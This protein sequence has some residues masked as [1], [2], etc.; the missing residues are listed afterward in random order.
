MTQAGCPLKQED[1]A[2][3]R[4]VAISFAPCH[5]LQ[6]E[7]K[8]FLLN[9][10]ALSPDPI[11]N[12]SARLLVV[13]D[14]P[15]VLLALSEIMREAGFEVFA[16]RDGEEALVLARKHPPDLV[17]LDVVLPDISG[18]D[19][20]R[21]I[22]AD[23]D[24]K[25]LFVVLLS[26]SETSPDSQVSGLDAG[27]DGYIARPIE[28]RELV[29]RVQSLLRIQRAEMALRKAHDELEQRVQDRTEALAR[30]NAGLRKMS[31]RLLEVQETE[32][33][34]LARELHDE[35]GQ[36]LT[37]LKMVVDRS[38]SAASE[39]MTGLLNEAVDLI[40]MLT[41]RMRDLSVQLRPQVLDDLGL[42]V[43]LEWHFQR[44]FTQT[45][46]QVHFSHTPITKRLPVLLETALFR[47]TLEAL[48]NVARHAGVSEV[49]V[50]VWVDSERVGLQVEDKGAGFDVDRIA[51]QR[52]STGVSGMRER[53]D[54]LDG[55]FTIESNPGKGTLM[56]VEFPLAAG[57]AALQNNESIL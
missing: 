37:S 13:D 54:L 51:A 14:N 53:A 17:L 1:S 46:I 28:N 56:T 8:I 25:F 42:I 3:I 57:S 4:G 36:L 45:K 43:A 18:V 30:A 10:S 35:A 55:E 32:R 44:Y 31:L 29:A 15:V 34:F 52:D 19:L 6:R 11:M 47:I 21:R 40:N 23:P 39:P 7:R 9:S 24:L 12:R 16:G 50:R 5:P 2:R 27:A 48:T 38:L 22:K 41:H 33:R 20:C 26:A 49:M